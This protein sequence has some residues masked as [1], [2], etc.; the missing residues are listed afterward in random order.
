MNDRQVWCEALVVE[1]ALFRVAK[2]RL[3]GDLEDEPA[4]LFRP[5]FSS[6]LLLLAFGFLADPAIESARRDDGDQLFDGSP[7]FLAVLE[8][9]RSFLWSRVDLAPGIRS[10]KMRFSSLR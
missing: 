5:E 10:R 9:L 1:D 7:D 2:A 3:F 8:Q 4:Q 6:S